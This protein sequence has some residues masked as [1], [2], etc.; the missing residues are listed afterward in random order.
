MTRRVRVG[1]WF[2]RLGAVLL[3]LSC[4][5]AVG[6]GEGGITRIGPVEIRELPRERFERPSTPES[7]LLAGPVALTTYGGMATIVS[8]RSSLRSGAFDLVASVNGSEFSRRRI[9]RLGENLSLIPLPDAG[10]ATLAVHQA[11]NAGPLDVLVL[12][13]EIDSVVPEVALETATSKATRFEAETGQLADPA[14]ENLVPNA[15]FAADDEVR[16]TPADWFAYVETTTN[17]LE[18]RLRVAGVAPG[19]RPF[20]A[21]API[22]VEPG[23]RYRVLVRLVVREGRIVVRVA[24]YEELAVIVEVGTAAAGDGPV[25]FLVEFTANDGTRAARIRFEPVAPGE[26]ADFE[27]SA[28]QME[29]LPG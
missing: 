11:P 5:L 26:R 17:E 19:W 2:V 4:V 14:V 23:R 7:V 27:L 15:S 6:C 3:S 16:G 10:S 28:I 1:G 9:E 18:R 21:T 25:E 13:A 20:L 24:D 29:L 22:R 8:V 12:R